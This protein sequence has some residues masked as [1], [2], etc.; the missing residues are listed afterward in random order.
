M[1]TTSLTCKLTTP[2][3]QL[4]KKTILT[5]LRK[6][7]RETVEMPDGFKYRFDGSDEMLDLLNDFIKTERMCCDFFEFT[8]TVGTEEAGVWLRLSGPEGTK[9]FIVE[10]L[11]LH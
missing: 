6:R 2:E 3:L 11:A 4:R 7:V 10:E 8:L 5:D 9:A 1:K